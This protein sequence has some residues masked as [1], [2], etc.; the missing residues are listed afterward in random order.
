VP[1][2]FRTRHEICPVF[3]MRGCMV[4]NKVRCDHSLQPQ[5]PGFFSG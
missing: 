5:R 3:V 2:C 1:A 4:R